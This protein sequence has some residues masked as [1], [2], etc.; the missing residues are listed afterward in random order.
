MIVLKDG[1]LPLVWQEVNG[2]MRLDTRGEHR[3]EQKWQGRKQI[4]RWVNEIEYS[5]GVGAGKKKVLLHVVI[6][7]ESWEVTD[8]NGCT[9]MKKA[10]HAWISSHPINRNN[11]HEQCNLGARKRWLHE[12]NILKEKHQGYHYEHIFSY[13]WGAMRGYHYLMHVARMLNEMAL[14][15]ISL[16]EQVKA[17]GFQPFIQKLREIMIHRELDIIRLHQLVQSSGQ[18]RLVQDE[19]WKTS[20]P[21]A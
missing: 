14:H 15:S 7:D 13:N 11:V 16:M 19:N 18:L 4:F 8:K 9:V 21:A 1:S 5:Y 2:L 12:N 6:C 20:R 10:R 17:V 3:R